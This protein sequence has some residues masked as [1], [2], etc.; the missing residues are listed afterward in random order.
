MDALLVRRAISRRRG[1]GD[2]CCFVCCREFAFDLLG[3]CLQGL[4][5]FFPEGV[6]DVA[7]ELVVVE[8]ALP[9]VEPC[10]LGFESLDGGFSCSLLVLVGARDF[11]AEPVEDLR[12]DDKV[13]ESHGELVGE[14]LL[15]GVGFG[16]FAAVPGAVV[17]PYGCRGCVGR[18][19]RCLW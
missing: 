8:R 14:C 12:W 4:V 10:S 17:V 3:L 6:R 19:S 11:L 9:V 7:V 16:A 2:H 1:E 13:A 15:S 18:S 5:F